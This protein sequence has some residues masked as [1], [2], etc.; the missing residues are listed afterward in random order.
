LGLH[1]AGSAGPDSD[2][3]MTHSLD[4][5]EEAKFE[6]ITRRR[7]Y[8][9][10]MS[11]LDHALSHLT[12]APL[13]ASL[14]NFRPGLRSVKLNS[15]LTRSTNLSE[16]LSFAELT[17]DRPI[18]VRFIEFMPFSGNEWDK[19]EMVSYEEALGILKVRY[20]EDLEMVRDD[21]D[22]GTS[23]RWRV[24]GYKG[25]IGFISSMVSFVLGR[26]IAPCCFGRLDIDTNR[27][28][29]GNRATTS[30]GLATDFE[31]RRTGTSKYAFTVSTS[32]VA[33]AN[34]SL[35]RVSQTLPAGLPVRQYRSLAP[36]CNALS[37]PELADRRT[38]DRC[39]LHGRG[40]Q[41]AETRRYGPFEV[42]AESEHGH[43]RG[44]I[45]A[46]LA[47]CV[48]DLGLGLYHIGVG[49]ART[50]LDWNC[51]D[52]GVIVSA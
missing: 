38:F 10:V 23:K 18:S 36:R 16:L 47:C 29:H 1:S 7:G 35:P 52:L 9:A 19:T 33:P 31:S 26:M 42:H 24:K 39:H 14:S 43:D 40:Q 49:L 11:A 32:R 8:S 25:E 45:E 44:L 5:L 17:K 30:A 51:R 12:D 3:W 20:G 50:G 21:G 2:S 15:V 46:T 28:W 13:H 22:D 34:A 41:E 4:T 37:R 6:E 48:W 27:N